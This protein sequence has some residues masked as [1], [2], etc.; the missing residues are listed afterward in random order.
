MASV[1]QN[2]GIWRQRTLIMFFL[3]LSSLDWRIP[4]WFILYATA[5]VI[6]AQ[7]LKILVPTAFLA[8]MWALCWC[9]LPCH[10][11]FCSSSLQFLSAYWNS[12]WGDGCGTLPFLLLWCHSYGQNSRILEYTLL[13]PSAMSLLYISLLRRNPSTIAI[14]SILNEH[15]IQFLKIVCFG[16]SSILLIHDGWPSTDKLIFVLYTE[17]KHLISMVSDNENLGKKEKVYN[18]GQKQTLRS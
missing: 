14:G 5:L 6:A 8:F 9:C 11:S 1:L 2:C 17:V 12:F 10:C 16:A 7:Y 13:S 3:K 4:S 15:P 18:M